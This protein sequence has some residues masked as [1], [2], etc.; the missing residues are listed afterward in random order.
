MA[1]QINLILLI[2]DKELKNKNSLWTKEQ[3]NCVK[4]EMEELYSYFKKGV[5]Y[6]K[7][8]KRHRML[9]STYIIND[10]MN[11][12]SLTLLGQEIIKLQDFYYKI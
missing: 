9:E 12:L 11:K 4:H 6:F 8:G 1:E 2:V 7:Y 10:S 5:E 3:L